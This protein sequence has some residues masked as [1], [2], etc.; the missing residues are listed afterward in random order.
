MKGAPVMRL[1]PITL[2][3][4]ADLYCDINLP[5]GL[6]LSSFEKTIEIEYLPGENSIFGI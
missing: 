1:G 2:K 3:V 5:L 4:A 6:P